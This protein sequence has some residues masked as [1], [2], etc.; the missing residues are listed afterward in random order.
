MQMICILLGVPEQER[1][2]LFEAVE[3]GF[4]HRGSRKAFE[5]D[6]ANDD[7]R[8]RMQAYGADLVAAALPEALLLA[9]TAPPLPSRGPPVFN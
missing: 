9:R 4:D 8:A 1:H 7:A 5:P 6:T 2:W 3:P